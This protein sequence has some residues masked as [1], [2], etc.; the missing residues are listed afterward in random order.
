MTSPKIYGIK[1]CSTVKKACVWLERHDIEYSLHDYKKSGIDEGAFNKAIKKHGW[2]N[3]IN[4][5]S[6]SWR[7]I[8]EVI[9]NAMNADNAIEAAQQ[10]TSLVKRP[11]LIYKDHIILGFNEDAYSEVF[12]V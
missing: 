3:V 6:P 2:D 1:N 12:K 9:Q 7:K 4:R 10:N 5:R 11:I 8:P